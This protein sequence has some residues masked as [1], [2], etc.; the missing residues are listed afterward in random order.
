MADFEIAVNKTI[1]NEG[2]DKY[3]ETP[4][5]NGGATKYGISLRFLLNLYGKNIT[6]SAEEF[7]NKLGSSIFDKDFVKN[8]TLE[9]AKFIY[10]ICFWDANRY[11]EI[12]DQAIAEKVFDMAVL[13]GAAKANK[14][15]QNALNLEIKNVQLKI[16]GIIGNNTLISLNNNEDNCKLELWLL[17]MYTNYFLSICNRDKSQTKFLLGWLNRVLG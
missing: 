16:D 4:G 1:S 14:I 17:H 7:Y 6:I 8:I 2:G 15:L 5:D 10:K 11:G 9:K 13:I 12:N 3:T